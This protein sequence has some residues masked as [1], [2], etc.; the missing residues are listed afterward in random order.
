LSNSSSRNEVSFSARLSIPAISC[1]R[2]ERKYLRFIRIR[3]TKPES[4]STSA[5]VNS[6]SS[7]SRK[8]F[9]L[10]PALMP[11][12]GRDGDAFRRGGRPHRRRAAAA[13]RAA[14]P[15]GA[16]RVPNRPQT[17]TD[18][19]CYCRK[20]ACPH[21]PRPRSR[22]IA[23]RRKRVCVAVKD[24]FPPAGPCSSNISAMPVRPKKFL[25]ASASARRCRR[26][27]PGSPESTA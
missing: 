26:N 3:L 1:G 12:T 5:P 10:R 25:R 19:C 23:P 22:I 13:I 11:G 7:A 24:G 27:R 6:D 2:M 16:P 17:N 8:R 20:L 9:S 18:Y 4:P 15:P 21:L 14:P